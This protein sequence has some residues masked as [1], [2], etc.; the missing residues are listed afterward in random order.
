MRALLH[1]A[2]L[3]L[4][5]AAFAASGPIRPGDAALKPD[6]IS[7][8][9]DTLL[10][11]FPRHGRLYV[12]GMLRLVTRAQEAHGTSAIV[13]VERTLAP[14]GTHAHTDSF[15]VARASLAPLYQATMT[16][17][18]DTTHAGAFDG[19]AFYRNAMDLV[20]ASLP[21]KKGY[22]AELAVDDGH[23][24]DGSV[25]RVEVA[26]RRAVATSSGPGCWAWEIR[27]TAEGVGGTYWISEAPRRLVRYVPPDESLV[28]ARKGGCPI[29]A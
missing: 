14:D 28:I 27:V 15:A 3:G 7:V 24:P 13:R 21:L 8:G 1:T 25:A 17:A 20:L 19:R 2:V 23:T 6:R 29:E 10:Y 9:E 4:A 22:T 11:L 26:G 5:L 16:A 12:G 18:G